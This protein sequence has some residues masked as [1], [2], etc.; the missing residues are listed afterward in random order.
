MGGRNGDKK[1]AIFLADQKGFAGPSSDTVKKYTKYPKK[2][3]FS[4]I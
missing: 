2:W 4:P 1:F 3:P